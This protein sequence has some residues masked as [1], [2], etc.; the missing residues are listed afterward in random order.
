MGVCLMLVVGAVEHALEA[1]DVIGAPHLDVAEECLYRRNR[2][3]IS[4]E[5]WINLDL[6]Y[7]LKA[8]IWSDVKLIIQTVGC[9]LTM[10]NTRYP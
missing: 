1:A 9:V 7:L 2:D 10:L 8:G 3:S 4:F 5:E 6:L